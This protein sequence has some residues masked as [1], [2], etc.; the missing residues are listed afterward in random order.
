MLMRFNVCIRRWDKFNSGGGHGMEQGSITRKV[1][2]KKEG[3][4]QR[5]MMSGCPLKK[6][7]GC[8][9]DLSASYESKEEIVS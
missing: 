3:N 1:Y 4:V 8:A 9:D 2:K 6:K 5:R 7:C